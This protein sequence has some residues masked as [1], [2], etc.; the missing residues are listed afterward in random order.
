MN[1]FLR[2]QNQD[3]AAHNAFDPISSLELQ[4][5]KC[6]YILIVWFIASGS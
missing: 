6:V 2:L 3:K 5:S 1:S 4:K